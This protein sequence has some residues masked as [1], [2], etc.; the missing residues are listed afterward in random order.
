MCVEENPA[1]PARHRVGDDARHLVDLVVGRLAFLAVVAHH[2]AADGAVPDVE[3]GVDA[4]LA[5]E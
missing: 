4:E 3:G 1:A 2:V 5:L